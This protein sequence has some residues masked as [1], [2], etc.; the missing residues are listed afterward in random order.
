MEK[1]K[2][3]LIC[4]QICELIKKT[5]NENVYDNIIT[6]LNLTSQLF[7]CRDE[8]EAMPVAQQEPTSFTRFFNREKAEKLDQTIRNQKE[9]KDCLYR[10]IS[11]AGRWPQGHNRTTKGEEV[12]KEKVYFGLK[13][14]EDGWHS[15]AELEKYRNTEPK[16][17]NSIASQMTM[18]IKKF[19]GCFD[20]TNWL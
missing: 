8:I 13:C 11:N 19:D 9:E 18:F 12:T 5:N 20:K 6:F 17:Y 7:D 16:I 14:L 2:L 4:S 10:A 3:K 1:E 15:I